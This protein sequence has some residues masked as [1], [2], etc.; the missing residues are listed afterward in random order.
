MTFPLVLHMSSRIPAGAGDV[1][2]NLW[3]Y[4]WWHKA[5]T[6]LGTS[7]LRT[8]YLFAPEGTEL[9]FHTHSPFNVLV[10]LPVTAIWGPAAA[11]NFSV[12]LALTLSGFGMWLLARELGAR[13][14]AALLGGIVFAFFPQHMEQLLEHVNLFSLQFMPWTLVYGLRWARRGGLANAVGLGGMFAATALCSWHL[15]LKLSLL[16]APLVVWAVWRSGRPRWHITKELGLAGAVAA[17]LVAPFVAPMAL[18]MAAAPAYYFKPSVDRGIDAA[19]LLTPQYE[20][21]VF[22]RSLTPAYALRAYQA[23]GFVCYLGFVPLLLACWGLV[24][25]WR[26]RW[27]WAVLA[28]GGLVLALGAR[29]YWNGELL[30]TVTLPFAAFESVPLYRALRVANRFLILTSL[31]L[32]VLASVGAARLPRASWRWAACALVLFEYLWLPF[33]LRSAAVSPYYEQ[34]AADASAGIVLDIPFNQRNRTVHNMT[35]QTVH[36][37]PIVAGYLSAFPPAPLQWIATEPALGPLSNVP[38]PNARVDVP[39]LR[40]LGIGT[41]IFHKSR[42]NSVAKQRLAEAEQDGGILTRKNALRL[43]GIPDETARALRAQ[44]EAVV[45]MPAWEDEEIV[46]YRIAAERP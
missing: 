40:E 38:Q 32:A 6:E 22:G 33:P 16:L 25:D 5:L 9:L 34:L 1:W 27:P 39:A 37:H 10:A 42:L 19:Y 4:W 11:Y 12:L 29:P 46:V 3:N 20:H 7:P 17:L 43:G 23:A 35:A 15:G 24:A 8:S 44:V 18:E 41:I 21:S 2:Q 30:E 28:L 26:A 31:G 14:P 36:G 45:G 13:G